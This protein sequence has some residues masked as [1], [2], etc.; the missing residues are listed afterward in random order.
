MKK[1]LNFQIGDLQNELK[2]SLIERAQKENG[3]IWKA[4]KIKK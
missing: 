2:Q 3:D 4:E 1:T